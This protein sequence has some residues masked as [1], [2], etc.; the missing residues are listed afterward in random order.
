MKN[1]INTHDANGAAKYFDDKVKFLDASVD[2]PQGRRENAK[3]QLIE[4]FMNAAPDLHWKM[5]GEPIV[6]GE[7][8]SFEWEGPDK[9]G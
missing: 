8:L 9:H 3:S 6:N 1:E 4:V 5:L 2:T 7:N